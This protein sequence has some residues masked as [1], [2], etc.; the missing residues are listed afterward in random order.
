MHPYQMFLYSVSLANAVLNL[1]CSCGSCQKYF[2]L[3]IIKWNIM[4]QT[5]LLAMK[6]MI[7]FL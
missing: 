4:P 5:I 3:F 1:Y 2:K 6:I 7:K